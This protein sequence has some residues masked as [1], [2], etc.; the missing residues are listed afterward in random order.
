M[1][2][3]NIALNFV[4]RTRTKKDLK[5]IIFSYVTGTFLFDIIGTLPAFLMGEAFEVYWLKIFRCIIHMF[6]LTQP[7]EMLMAIC[8]KKYSKKR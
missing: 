2:L 7:L 8:L 3:F 5:T 6:W 4:K 1:W